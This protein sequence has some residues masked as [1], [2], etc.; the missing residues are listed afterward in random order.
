LF[1]V[2]NILI[3]DDVVDAPFSCNLG[4]CK[5]A[6][7]VQGDSGAPLEPDERAEVER[8]LEVVRSSL[9]PEALAV[10]E[11]QGPWEESSPGYYATTC[12]GDAEC[13]FVV[14]D[15]RVA[16]CAIQ[17][18]FHEGKLDFEKPISCHLYPI[19]VED[20]GDYEA[21]NYEQAPMCEPAIAHGRRTG[22]LLPNFLRDPLVR[23]YGESWYRDFVDACEARREML[24][25]SDDSS[26]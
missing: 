23:K 15:G 3:S 2:G 11:A 9:R 4:A 10:I 6:C 25:G 20:L 1:A 7:C 17:K 19:R 22:A 14:Y 13:V 5:G 18:A 12:V 21:L 26:L 8:A 16:K 24:H